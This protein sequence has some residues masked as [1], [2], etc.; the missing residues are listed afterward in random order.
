MLDRVVGGGGLSLEGFLWMRIQLGD[1]EVG[2]RLQPD[3]KS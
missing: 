2:A 1:A 3:G